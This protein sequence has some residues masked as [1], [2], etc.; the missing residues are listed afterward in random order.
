[1][2]VFFMNIRWPFQG[3]RPLTMLS[4]KVLHACLDIRNF[5]SQAQLLFYVQWCLRKKCNFTS[6]FLLYYTDTFIWTFSKVTF[7]AIWCLRGPT[8][9]YKHTLTKCV[10]V[11]I[12]T[13]NLSTSKRGWMSKRRMAFVYESQFA[14]FSFINRFANFK[15][16]V[17]LRYFQ[18]GSTFSRLLFSGWYSFYTLYV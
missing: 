18:I 2:C 1:M 16:R 9:R 17:F 5:H 3:K 4:E 11:Y 13:E 7:Y 12:L 15:L 8:I 14:W 10:H 6:S